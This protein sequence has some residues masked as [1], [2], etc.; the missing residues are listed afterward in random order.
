MVAVAEGVGDGDGGRWRQ[1]LRA[2]VTVVVDDGGGTVVVAGVRVPVCGSSIGGDSGGAG[3]GGVYS[4]ARVPM[5]NTCTPRVLII[6][7]FLLTELLHVIELD[8]HSLYSH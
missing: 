7:I 5:A 8:T 6:N 1:W 4:R 3:C 2:W